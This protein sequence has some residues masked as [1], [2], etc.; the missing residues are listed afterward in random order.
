MCQLMSQCKAAIKP[1]LVTVCFTAVTAESNFIV[2]IYRIFK[3]CLLSDSSSQRSYCSAFSL[4]LSWSYYENFISNQHNI[5]MLVFHF[6]EAILFTCSK[7][8]SKVSNLGSICEGLSG[9]LPKLERVA[10]VSTLHKRFVAQ[11]KME[12]MRAMDCKAFVFAGFLRGYLWRVFKSR[13][14]MNQTM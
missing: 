11:H 9:Q 10:D 3:H 4:M 14:F 13:D 12:I 2:D 6:G 1:Y 8:S 7:N 5:H